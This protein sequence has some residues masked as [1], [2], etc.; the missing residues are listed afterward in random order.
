MPSFWFGLLLMLLFSLYLKWLPA[1]WSLWEGHDQ[2]N[3]F[4]RALDQIR[5]FTL[6]VLMGVFGGSAYMSRYMRTQMLDVIRQD[7]VRTARSKG[8]SEGKVVYKH[9]LRNA[10]LPMV[11][12]MTFTLPGLLGGSPIVE[13]IFNINGMGKMMLSAVT[14]ADIPVAMGTLTMFAFLNLLSLILADI[15]Y[16]SVDPRITFS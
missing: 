11:T 5:N 16:A 6:P 2:M 14:A 8:L 9:A 3:I 15:L 4:M 1:G 10:L 13:Q 12:L 7:Y